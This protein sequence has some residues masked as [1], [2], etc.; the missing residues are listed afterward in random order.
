MVIRAVWRPPNRSQVYWAIAHLFPLN[1]DN[2]F[3][4]HFPLGAVTLCNEMWDPD[5]GMVTAAFK[6]KRKPIQDFYQ[7]DI[8]R[9]YGVSRGA[10]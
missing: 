1:E 10:A 8:D 9:M 3:R 2:A 5:S 6:I 7:K 4:F